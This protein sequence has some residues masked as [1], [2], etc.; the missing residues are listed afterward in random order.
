VREPALGEGAEAQ[1]ERGVEHDVGPERG[2]P[3]VPEDIGIEA[4]GD[5]V[6]S[7]SYEKENTDFRT[8]SSVPKDK[9]NSN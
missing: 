7:G 2:H 4:L 8:L 6:R 5:L 3:E 1:P 9:G